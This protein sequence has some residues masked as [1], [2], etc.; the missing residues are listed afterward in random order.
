[1]ERRR[2]EMWRRNVDMGVF[3]MVAFIVMISVAGG[4]IKTALRAKALGERSGKRFDELAERFERIEDRLANVETIAI[5]LEK[6]NKFSTLE[7]QPDR[8]PD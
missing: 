5:D 7:M 2:I 6:Q 4:V 1:M 3:E 8:K